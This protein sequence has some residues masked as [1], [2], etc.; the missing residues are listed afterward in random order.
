MERISPTQRSESIPW[1]CQFL[2]KIHTL[3]QH[4][5][6]TSHQTN[7]EHSVLLLETWSNNGI[8]GMERGIHNCTCASS[9]REWI[10]NSL[11]NQCIMLRHSGSTFTIWQ[12]RYSIPKTFFSKKTPSG[13]GKLYD[14]QSGTG[15]HY[16]KIGTME[17]RMWRICTPYCNPNKPQK[18]RILHDIKTTQQ[19]ANAMVRILIKIWV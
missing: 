12:P 3:Q 8:C 9:L 13:R 1:I 19:E 4:R 16:Q 6:P 11:R 5:I 18:H 2:L 15:C 10:S 17:T 14:L 7:K